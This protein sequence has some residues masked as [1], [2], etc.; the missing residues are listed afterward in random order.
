MEDETCIPCCD[1]C[2]FY[3]DN[4]GGLEKRGGF[5]GSGTCL[6]L[7]QETMAS[8]SCDDFICAICNPLYQGK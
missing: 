6:Y 8:D 5:S 7:D 1:Y 3:R 4:G 2:K